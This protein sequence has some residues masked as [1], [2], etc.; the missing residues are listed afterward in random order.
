MYNK[1]FIPLQHSVE[2]VYFSIIIWYT[3]TLSFTL[4]QIYQGLIERF[5]NFCTIF[6]A[7]NQTT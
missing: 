1:L 7:E 2:V 6:A 4:C 5:C 3:F